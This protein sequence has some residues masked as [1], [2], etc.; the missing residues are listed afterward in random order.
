MIFFLTILLFYLF[1]KY[2]LNKSKL[3]IVRLQKDNTKQILQTKT[4]KKALKQIKK[5]VFVKN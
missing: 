1:S 3:R 2:N 4:S 5:Q